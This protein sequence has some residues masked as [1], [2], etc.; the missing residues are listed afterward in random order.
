MN[1]DSTS[2]RIASFS[3]GGSPIPITGHGLE[4][5][6]ELPLLVGGVRQ[7]RLTQREP[8]LGQRRDG[9]LTLLGGGE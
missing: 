7:Q 6:C 4:P 1:Q 2:A 8:H 3:V 9:I 5:P